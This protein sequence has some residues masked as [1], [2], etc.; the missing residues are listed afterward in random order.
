M[1][2]ILAAITNNYVLLATD[3]RLT[4][5]VGPKKGQLFDDDTCKLVNFC[6]YS[7]L[8]YSGLAQIEGKATHEWIACALADANCSDIGTAGKIIRDR[9]TQAF[10]KLPPSTRRHVFVMAG[11]AQ[12]KKF[13]GLRPHVGVISNYLDSDWRPLPDSRP[14]F[15]FTTRVLNEDGP[16]Y[17]A[18]FG[19]PLGEDRYHAFT[20]NM[21]R[22][23]TRDIGPAEALRLL[24]DE[25]LSTSSRQPTV[26]SRILALSI[27]KQ[28]VERQLNSGSSS[29]KGLPPTRENVTFAYFQPGYSEL[30]QY[31]P[32]LVCGGFAVTNLQL[33]TDS[34][35]TDQSLEFKILAAPKT[36]PTPTEDAGPTMVIGLGGNR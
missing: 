17:W 11:W 9:A 21:N 36:S 5:A 27:P 3:R 23:V 20:R 12:F 35:T 1:T 14:T 4:Y 30:Q 15:D 34:S 16:V 24:V 6:N 25:I 32:T 13:P 28:C 29:M 33:T 7:G 18:A 19:Q 10:S 8:A 22:L 2:Q 31:G 26:G